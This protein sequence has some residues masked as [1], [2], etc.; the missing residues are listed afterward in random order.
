[1]AVAFDAAMTGGN[2]GT[3]TVQEGTGATSLSTAGMTIGASATLLVACVSLQC[4]TT[5]STGVT[6]TWNGVSMTVGPTITHGAAN[7]TT[8]A[9]FWLVNPATGSHTLAMSWTL[10][11]DAYMGCASFTGVDT[12]TPV[13]TADNQTT[14]VANAVTITTVSGDA[15]VA[16]SCNNSNTPTSSKTIFYGESNLN[17]GGGGSYSLS[18][19]TSDTHTFTYSGGTLPATAGIHIQAAA[20]G[21]PPPPT[22]IVTFRRRQQP[23]SVV[24]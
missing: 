10:A 19:T 20:G 17:P 6:A 18:T 12:T 2:A 7:G 9:I 24:V 11:A 15:T 23:V 22:A 21:G 14:S 1:M 16:C 8:V 5:A 13:V 4:N 3:G